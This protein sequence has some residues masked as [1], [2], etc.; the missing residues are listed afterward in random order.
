MARNLLAALVAGTLFLL[1]SCSGGSHGSGATCAQGSGSCAISASQGS[2]VSLANGP[3]IQVPANALAA[4]T[5]ISIEQATAPAPSTALSFVYSFAPSGTTFNTSATVSFPVPAGTTEALILWSVAGSTQY[6]SLA[7][8]VTG[9]LASAQV[10]QLGL[11][12]LSLC[13]TSG[14]ACCSDNLCSG[15][16]TCASGTC[17]SCE[18][19][20]ACCSGNVC[21]DLLVCTS[22]TCQ[23][24][25]AAGEACCS[26]NVCDSSLV[27]T[28]GTCQNCGAPGEACCSGNECNSSSICT[29][30]I[31]QVDLTCGTEG[32]ACCPGYACDGGFG[33]TSA[34]CQ[35]C[36]HDEEPCC[37]GSQCFDGLGCFG[38][39]PNNLCH[40]T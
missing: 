27:C 35:P 40:Q 23:A 39:P 2:E 24:C 36:G 13:G 22:G 14:E 10:T 6:E 21:S 8:T 9:G 26:D 18:Q 28:S 4:D 37:A 34:G 29:G 19:G 38:G 16:L 3:S 15:R 31:C 1:A 11:G 17:Q 12:Y 5:T 32:Q 25:G 30:G 20:E 33:C 7:T